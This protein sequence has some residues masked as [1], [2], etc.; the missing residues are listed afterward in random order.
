MQTKRVYFIDG[1]FKNTPISN[2]E[3]RGLFFADSIYEVIRALHG[4][5]I[6][7][8]EHLERLFFGLRELKIQS[9][10]TKEE[11]RDI[12]EKSLKKLKAS[13][14]LV[15]IQVTRGKEPR[16]HL[17]RKNTKPT[18]IIISSK[19]RP[20][21]PKL[22]KNGVSLILY[23]DVRWGRCD[24][25]TTMLLP[26]VLAKIEA[27][28]RGFFD[29]LFFKNG[30]LTESTSSSFFAV[31]GGKIFTHPLTHDILPS[32]T[33]QAVIKICKELG[34]QVVE[35][36]IKIESI[37]DLDGAFLAGTTYDIL[38]I[39]A[40]EDIKIPLSA[41]TTKIQWEYERFLLKQTEIHINRKAK[42]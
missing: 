25:K 42:H 12:I 6:F 3:D 27:R 9:P 21:S 37:K 36:P 14:A 1:K 4:I 13:D 22:K 19:Y 35:D 20:L 31:I 5:P 7:L 30:Y 2:I 24:I 8:E 32:I 39:N 34:I 33:R 29:A 38:P 23:P 15:Y 16:S 18:V 28:E 10:Y 41:I 17:P 11:Y 26:N 40:I